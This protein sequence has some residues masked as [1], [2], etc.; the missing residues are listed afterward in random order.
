MSVSVKALRRNC[1]LTGFVLATLLLAGCAPALPPATTS[2]S[3]ARACIALFEQVDRR[4]MAAGSGDGG[5]HRLPAYP[6]LRISRFYASFASRIDSGRFDEAAFDSWLDHLARLDAQARRI[7]LNNLP[8]AERAALGN[9]IG[10]RL[11]SCR[12]LLVATQFTQPGER[13]RLIQAAMV[14]DDYLTLN[15]IAG[16]YPLSA[17]FVA[18]GVKRWHEEERQTYAIALKQLPV[19]GRLTRWRSHKG[20]PLTSPEVASI[21]KRSLDPLG[22]P[23]PDSEQLSRLFDTFA[24]L[25][26][27]DVVDNND[28]IGTPLWKHGTL[29]VAVDRAAIFHKLSYTRYHGETLLQL[30]Y[31]V[32]FP[33]RDSGDIYGGEIDG[34][35]WRVTLGH[36]GEVLLYD[37]IHNCGCYQKFYPGKQLRL[38]SDLPTSYFEAPMAPQPAPAGLPV[39]IRISHTN[40]FIQ[41]VYRASG[42]AMQPSALPLT[43]R[44]Y[45]TL[46]SLP[47]ASGHRSIFDEEGIVRQSRRPERF[48]L[49]PMGVR[50]AGAMR[51]WGR[52]NTAFVGKRHFDDPELIESLFERVAP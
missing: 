49:W 30:N 43:V 5:D 16:L 24:P 27:V 45:D 31:I 38:R 36:D 6:Y 39:T 47:T 42:A 18:S 32:W 23:E 8:A 1:L 22:I 41:R 12:Q 50:S 2:H 28:R 9:D 46:R 10:E 25:W 34:I 26:E 37:S 4:I 7:E 35:N 17:L 51:Q 44:D 14:P 52:H 11:N 19:E 15:R 33:A 29:S 40:H 20:E 3:E 13:R 21:L 48:I